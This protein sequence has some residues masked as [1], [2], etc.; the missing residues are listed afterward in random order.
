MRK[1]RETAIRIL[2]KVEEL[3]NRKGV[4]VPSEDRENEKG[5]ACLFGREYY[6][7]EDNITE[8]LKDSG[9]TPSR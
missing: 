3:F 2:D 9:T 5:E 6:Q 1:E 4:R 7:L 8:I